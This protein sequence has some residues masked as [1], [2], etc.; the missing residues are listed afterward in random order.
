MIGAAWR[1]WGT[2]LRGAG[3]GGSG[4]TTTG[5]AGAVFFGA[6]GSAGL[7]GAAAAGRTRAAASCSFFCRMAFS[8][9]PGLETLDKSIFGLGALSARDVAAPDL[10]RC[11]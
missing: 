10:P 9:S 8:T 1:G 11:R 5:A 4:A 2:I 3:F 7:I 6:A